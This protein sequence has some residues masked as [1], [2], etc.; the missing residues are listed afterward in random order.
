MKAFANSIL[1]LFLVLS[2]YSSW[3]A[4]TQTETNEA[5]QNL[6]LECAAA[7]G[8]QRVFSEK[9]SEFEKLMSGNRT[10]LCRQ[11]LIFM[12][13]KNDQADLP[14]EAGWAVIALFQNMK[15]TDQEKFAALVPL[16]DTGKLTLEGPDDEEMGRQLLRNIDRAHKKQKPDFHLYKNL[17]DER[18]QNPPQWLT[19]HMYESAP[20]DALSTMANVYLKKDEAEALMDKAKDKDEGKALDLLS[21][22]SEW[23]A[24]LYVAEKMK[25][26]PKLR[27]ATVLERLKKSK[28]ALVQ[29]AVQKIEKK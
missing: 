25:K 27:S 14:N 9:A 5:V 4:S 17:M 24:H 3:A 1:S 18:K 29:E 28:H 10:N 21:K 11:L 26:N 2:A 6:I 16:M 13:T 22:R 20:T 19:K 23:W 12:T 7:S 8:D 15:F